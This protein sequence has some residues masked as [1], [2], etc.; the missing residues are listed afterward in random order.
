ML[1]YDLSSDDKLQTDDKTDD[2]LWPIKRGL[3]AFVI[4]SS[5][6][7]LLYKEKKKKRRR[8]R[9]YKIFTPIYKNT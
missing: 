8:K 9:E 3:R 7:F 1:L 2:K 6:T 4:M 5:V